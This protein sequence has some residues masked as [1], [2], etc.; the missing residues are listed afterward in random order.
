MAKNSSPLM[1]D[2]S[3]I[4]PRDIKL[5]TMVFLIFSFLCGGAFG[6]EEMISASGP[7]LT[8]LLLIILPFL[9]AIPQAFTAA[10]LGS[11]IPYTGGFYKWNQVALGEFWGFTAGWCRSLAQYA[12]M[13]V[14]VVLAVNYLG[15]M[16]PLSGV[17]S[18]IIKAAI[19]LF[20]T[21]LNLR[22]IKE[23]GWASTIL[24][25]IVLSAFAFVTVVGFANWNTNPFEPVYNPDEGFV[26]SLSGALAI[27]MWMFSGYTSVSTLA[28]DVKD[29]SIVYK[30]LL[31]GL[32]IIA[33]TYILP[34]MAGVAATGEGSWAEWGS[35]SINYGTVAGMAGAGFAT[36]FVVV[37]IVGN[38][39]CFN[40]CMISLSRGFYAICEDN[41]GPNIMVK[42][43]K[44]RGIPYIS[45]ISVA[46]VAL[47]GC[48]FDFSTIITVT[49]TLLMVDYVL[50][51]ISVVVMR[52]KHPDMNR[53]FRIPFGT[54]GVI[55]FVSPGIIIALIALM[56]N[57]ADYFFGGMIGFA[58][59]PVLYIYFKRT[60][61]GLT[62]LY[63]DRYPINPKTKLAYGDLTRFTKI[64][65][66]LTTLSFVACFFMP[67]YEGSWGPEYY[68]DTYG[69]ENAYN[70][71]IS[72]IKYVTIIY[73]V[74]TVILGILAKK[75]D[76]KSMRPEGIA[77][78]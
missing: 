1:G 78:S 26:W 70:I 5:Y 62:K 59:I 45:V 69:A 51:W 74:I 30:G 29:K 12:E 35:D 76:N 27:G 67:F 14:Y 32:P 16:L 71:I 22:G 6:I 44:K 39:S 42:V 77:N 72:G 66:L 3:K 63:P 15:Y 23:V 65:A 37:A 41:L 28:G 46:I 34:T 61:G 36:A 17:E 21:F 8:L 58:L 19:I 7:G 31:I 50:I 56:I 57:G 53:P 75:F 40:T 10:E 13:S 11:A 20:F 54:K 68:M 64:F 60:H 33:L 49:V 73:A 48:T 24:S 38:A 52:I 9:W 43:S 4:I 55:A 25:L 2:N 18:Y 47:L